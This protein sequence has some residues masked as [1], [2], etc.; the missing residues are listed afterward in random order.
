MARGNRNS[1]EAGALVL[2]VALAVLVIGIVRLL[3][4]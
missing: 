4:S 2:V 1:R 3:K